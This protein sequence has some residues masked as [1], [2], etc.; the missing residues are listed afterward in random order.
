M[1]IGYISVV[2]TVGLLGGGTGGLSLGLGQQQQQ[3]QGE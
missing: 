2:H 3:K 1:C